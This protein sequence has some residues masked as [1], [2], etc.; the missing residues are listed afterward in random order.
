MAPLYFA[1]AI[2]FSY[3][4]PLTVS[5]PISS[6]TTDFTRGCTYNGF[7]QSTF[8]FGNLNFA[9]QC[10]SWCWYLDIEFQCFLVMMLVVM[11]YKK[12]KLAGW[13]VL[14]LLVWVP[15]LTT[16]N[17]F[18]WSDKVV[19]IPQTDIARNSLEN[20]FFTNYYT[21]SYTR[22]LPYILGGMFGLYMAQ[23]LEEKIP[24][25]F[26]NNPLVCGDTAREDLFIDTE[27]AMM[28]GLESRLPVSSSRTVTS[29]GGLPK[30]DITYNV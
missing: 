11:A 20:P 24:N 3:V 1:M 28:A 25:E 17:Q 2:I 7:W 9:N 18:L 16:M 6:L 10:M 29:I 26:N 19:T 21:Q 22:C 30:R 4:T 15:I 13:V 14:A 12:L 5:G 23:K 8:F 27:K